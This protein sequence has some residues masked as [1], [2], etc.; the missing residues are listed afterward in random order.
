MLTQT[1][2]IKHLKEMA[3]EIL[4][5]GV[6]L[7]IIVLYGSYSRNEQHKR[8]DVDIAIVADEFTGIGFDDVGLFART[9]VKR[10]ELST[11]PRTYNTKN[12]SPDHDPFVE[13]ILRTGIDINFTTGYE[14]PWG[15]AVTHSSKI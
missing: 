12:F 11:Q 5:S 1:S 14:I 8:S 4:Q 6:H 15:S 2:V 10:A 7:K 9:L 13:E 3:A